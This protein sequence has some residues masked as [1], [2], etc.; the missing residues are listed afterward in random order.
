MIHLL[1]DVGREDEFFPRELFA[2]GYWARSVAVLPL[3]PGFIRPTIASFVHDDTWTVRSHNTFG[4]H[5]ISPGRPWPH[6]GF[7]G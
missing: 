5:V 7:P 4:F 2:T 6:Y 1:L 3:V